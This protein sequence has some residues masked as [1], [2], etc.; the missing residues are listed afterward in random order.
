MCPLHRQ[1]RDAA[2]FEESVVDFFACERSIVGYLVCHCGLLRG[3]TMK[4]SVLEVLGCPMSGGGQP[5]LA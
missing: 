1:I 3:F 2:A 4:R 5:T